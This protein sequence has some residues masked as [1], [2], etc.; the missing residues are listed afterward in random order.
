MSIKRLPDYIINQICA[1]EIAERP[2][3]IVKELIENSI[4]GGAS[5]IKI[6]LE[7]AGKSK[8][9]IWD[10]GC[11]M[12][13][14]DLLLSVE[15]HTTSKLKTD[16]LF[17]ICS[18]GFRGEALASIASVSKLK[19]VSAKNN[20][21]WELK[22]DGGNVL[23]CIPATRIQG[24]TV[25]VRDLFYKIPARAKFL[26]SDKSEMLAINNMVEKIALSHP[27]I[28]FN[29]NDKLKFSSG[30]YDNRVKEI[31][32]KD[33]FENSIKID[34][35]KDDYKLEGFISLPQ[36]NKGNSLGIFLFVNGR[37]VR[38]KNLS[39][40]IKVAYQDVMAYDRYP[41]CIL[42]FI[43][44]PHEVDINVHPSKMEVRFLQEQKVRSFILSVLKQ[45]LNDYTLRESADA[46]NNFNE[47][48]KIAS[49]VVAS[50]IKESNIFN[51]DYKRE[52]NTGVKVVQKSVVEFEMP[53]EY[54]LGYAV[55]QMFRTYILSKSGNDFYIVDQHAVH[56]RIVLEKLHEK[57]YK[58][59]P[60]L[61]ADTFELPVK[62]V[63]IL[64]D[65][66]KDIEDLG[67][68]FEI[69]KN[70]ISITQVPDFLLK[71]NLK[72]IFVKICEEIEEFDNSNHLNKIVHKIKS[73]IACHG[74]IRSGQELSIDEMNAVLRQLEV[75]P[76]ASVCNHGRPT[77]FKVD[78]KW[79]D[80]LFERI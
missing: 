79:F 14:D 21:A 76:K 17:D 65:A 37:T 33:F 3:S 61:I 32:G 28:S 27:A 11:G 42:N 2:S 46:V 64:K 38:D 20:E 45:H 31:M 26:K 52:N 60:L 50:E 1:G 8:I 10:D 71:Q 62:Y 67:I 56:E 5:N 18:L 13:K 44:D 34:S 43:C 74:S 55:A 15:R 24:T 41:V 48:V 35:V 51:F 75:T 59:Q 16:D 4:D 78:K 25:E 68:K 73:T 40:L 6:L 22:V 19:I 69:S 47:T 77:F 80:K 7:D 30:S 9:V 63:D 39:A 54:P 66:K 12:N 72:N 53:Q 70:I 57:E 23:G 36:F 29:V 49:Q 58:K